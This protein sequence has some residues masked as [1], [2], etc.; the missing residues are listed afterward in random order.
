MQYGDGEALDR[1]ILGFTQGQVKE[2]SDY[3][4]GE[5]LITDCSTI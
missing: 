1:S 2:I 3:D 4:D 5:V